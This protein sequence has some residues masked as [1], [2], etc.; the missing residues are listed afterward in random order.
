MRRGGKVLFRK[1][2][3]E[4]R[5][6]RQHLF[7]DDVCTTTENYLIMSRYFAVT[8][9]ISKNKTKHMMPLIFGMVW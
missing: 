7:D 6:K 5:N 1:K 3:R 8:R 4:T 2:Q 9:T